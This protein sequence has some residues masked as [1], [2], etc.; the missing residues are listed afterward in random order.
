MEIIEFAVLSF[1]L[2]ALLFWIVKRQGIASVEGFC[3]AWLVAS[4]LT[5]NLK[6]LFDYFVQPGTLPLGVEEFNFRAYPT[7]VH[8]I[9]LIVLM[10]GLFLGNPK[11]E[12]ISREFSVSELDFVAHTGAALVVVGLTLTGFAIYLTGAYSA[13]NFYE[14]LDTFRSG[15]PGKWGGF[16]YRGADIAALGMAL[17]LPRMAKRVTSFLLLLLAMMSVAFFLRANKGGFETALI[18]A[19]L[20]VHTYNPRRFWSLVKPRVALACLIVALVGIA[21]KVEVRGN[22]AESSTLER[23]TQSIVTPLQDRWGDQGLY[24]GY[25]QFINLLPRYHYLFEGYAEGMD[26]LTSWVPRAFNPKKRS[27]SQGLGFMI[28]A[29]AHSYAEEHPAIGL[30]GSVYADNG[31]YTLTAYLL[32]VGF[33]LGVLRRYAAGRQSKL[34]WHVSYFMFAV[35]GGLSAEAGIATVPYV[36]ILAFVFAGLAHLL[37]IGLYRRK[38]HAS[39]I[40]VHSVPRRSLSTV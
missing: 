27:P 9:A 34:Q 2:I 12:P 37:V 14:A 22:A 30:V 35:L 10:A 21:V 31:F 15:V 3:A 19:A 23:M 18:Y 4:V 7:I 6:L 16:W 17:I 36:F 28:Y 5:D 25:C 38:V 8:L 20:A 26:T 1:C 39:S 24:R 33:L 13:P 11:P 40:P 32:I 29:D